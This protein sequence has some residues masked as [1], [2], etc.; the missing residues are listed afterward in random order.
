MIPEFRTRLAGHSVNEAHRARR[1]HRVDRSI[2]YRRDHGFPRF[3][4][5]LS[6]GVEKVTDCIGRPGTA[7]RHGSEQQRARDDKGK[8]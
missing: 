7:A 5:N 2:C 1:R 6:R 4:D 3:G 8:A